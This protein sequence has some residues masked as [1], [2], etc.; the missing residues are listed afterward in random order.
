MLL[1][2]QQQETN[3]VFTCSVVVADN[4]AAG[5]A[6]AVVDEVISATNLRIIYCIEPERNLALV[7]NKTLAHASGDFIAL[8]DDD[9]FPVKDWLL[10]LFNTCH[11][12]NVD[13]ALGPVVPYFDTEPPAWVKRGG[14]FDRPRH[15]TGFI[16]DWTE[17]RTGNLLFNRRLMEGR[18]D[19]FRPEFGSGGEDRDLFRRWIGAGKRFAWCDEAVAYESVPPVRWNRSFMIRRAL[20]RGKMSL[21]HSEA[22]L[23]NL[24]RSL[25]AVPLYALAL[26]FLW[27]AGQHLF[28]KYLI[29]LFDHVGRLLAW[30]GFRPV[31]E[32]YVTE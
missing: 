14:F 31:K 4:D 32:I 30:L 1:A 2:I 18:T 6:Q 24:L 19:L 12:C 25:L 8:I 28:T 17:G 22:R 16:I 9:E 15:E 27:L 5:S 13:G 26:P 3:G 11:A 21:Q 29:S 10:A 23:V 7:R 20:L